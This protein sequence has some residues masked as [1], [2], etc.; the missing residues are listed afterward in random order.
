M[1][2]GFLGRDG[3]GLPQR[4]GVLQLGGAD[5]DVASVRRVRVGRMR[6]GTGAG[7]E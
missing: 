6:V 1:P 2:V 3:V 5:Y 7:V 4:F